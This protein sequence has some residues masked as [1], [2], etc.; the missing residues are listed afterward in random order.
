MDPVGCPPP[1]RRDSDR[2]QLGGE[3][4][5]KGC[6]MMNLEMER[7]GASGIGLA[8]IADEDRVLDTW[9]GT[10]RLENSI[11]A[12]GTQPLSKDE[13][14]MGGYKGWKESFDR[15]RQ[16]RI[17]P[18]RTLVADLA[19][20]PKD[21]HDVYLR[22]HLL[23]HRVIR[24][25]E[26]NLEGLFSL[27]PMVAWTSVGPCLVEQVEELRWAARRGDEPC[28]IKGIFK[29]PGLLDYVVPKGVAIANADR[30]ALGAHLAPGTLVSPEGFCSFNAGTLGPAMVEGRLSAGVIVDEGSDIGGGASIMG[31]LSGGGKQVISVGKN[32]LLGAN[33]GLGISLGDNCV[34]EAGC[35]ITA[36]APVRLTSGAIVKAMEL[37]G[38]PNLLFRRESQTGRLEAIN[39][40]AKWTG[41][42]PALH[43]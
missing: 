13:L 41:L 17:V 8:T 30:V 15:R 14:A 39:N 24:P 9:F 27:L 35:Y 19:S 31:T 29:L 37:S 12:A 6:R 23:S 25:R 2:R 28:D 10:M 21:V 32:C 36:G 4:V 1:V 40:N 34:V 43:D 22:L 38:R 18:V 16:V 7:I 11:E 5:F 20:P 33:S 3:N 42:N 26:A